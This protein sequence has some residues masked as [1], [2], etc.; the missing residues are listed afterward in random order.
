[1]VTLNWIVAVAEVQ[2]AEVAL[3]EL[4][5]VDL[6]GHHRVAAVRAH[7]VEM[8]GD[9]ESARALYREAARQTLSVPE[10]RYLEGRAS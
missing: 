2:G 9:R 10:R 1:M 7:L 3:R 8:T 4:D 6:G 5:A